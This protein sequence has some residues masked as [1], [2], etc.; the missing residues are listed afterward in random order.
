[1]REV[2]IIEIDMDR[3]CTSCG[4]AGAMPSGLCL[5]CAGDAIERAR[6]RQ[7]GEFRKADGSVIEMANDL[8]EQYHTIL[9]HANIGILFKDE[10]PVSRGK[11][12]LGKAIK[13][14]DRMKVYTGLDFII[15]LAWD[16]WQR[17]TDAQRLA[18]IDHE[19]CH[20]GMGTAGWAIRPHDIEEFTEVIERHGFYTRD[21]WKVERIA[22]GQQLPL[23]KPGGSV[24]AVEPANAAGIE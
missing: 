18:L 17:L 19:L 24:V 15:W 11:T 3:E 10:A 4:A 1:M 2:P 14:T 9:K 8:I 16:E 12:T 5:D 23:F 6:E 22:K 7:V 21:L 13:V 20:C